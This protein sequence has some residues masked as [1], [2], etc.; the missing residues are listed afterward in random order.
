MGKVYLVRSRSSRL[1]FAVKRAKGLGDSERRNFLAELQTWIGLPDHSNLVPCRFFRTV[2][3]ETLIFA[4]YVDGGSLSQWIESRRLYEGGPKVALERMLDVAIQFAW[5]LHCLHELGLVH[6]DVKP[7]NVLMAGDGKAAV[8]GVKAR[9]TD[10]G[11]ARAKAAGGERVIPEPGRGILVSSG[12][13][14][15]AYCSPEQAARQPLSSKTDMW[16]WGVSVLEMFT[17]EVTWHSGQV[18]AEVL[19]EYLR[20]SENDGLIPAMPAGVVE[21]LKG[22]FRG[23]PAQ[24]WKSLAEVVDRLKAVFRDTAGVQY[25]L[26]LDGIDR[27]T[28][29]QSGIKERRTREGAPWIDPREWLERALRAEGRDPAEA[30]ALVSKHGGSRRGELVGDL[31]IYD[32]SRR[33]YERLL[34]AGRKELESELAELC[35]NKAL[36]HRTTDDIP[37]AL[38]E[39]DRAIEI[40]ERLVHKEK[41]WD[42]ASAL[43]GDY[44]NKAASVSLLGNHREAAALIERAIEVFERLVHQEKRWDLAN[45]LAAAYLN[46]AVAVRALGDHKMAAALGDRGIEIYERL[47]RKAGQQELAKDL[48]MAYMNKAVSVQ[49]EQQQSAVELYHRAIEILERLVHQEGQ[50]ELFHNLATAYMD[51][52][53]VVR[54]LG[55]TRAAMGLYDRAMEIWERLVHKEGRRELAENLANAYINKAVA[56]EN[57]EDNQV[58]LGLYARAIELLERLVRQ[59]GRRELSSILAVAYLNKANVM[60]ASGQRQAAL[61]LYDQGIEIRERLVNREG[62]RELAGDLAYARAARAW[63]MIDLGE[64]ARGAKE[65][66][67]ATDM[68]H[69]EIASS[70]RADL[71]LAMQWIT[72][73]ISSPR[74]P[75]KPLLQTKAQPGPLSKPLNPTPFFMP[76]PS[77]ARRVIP[78]EA[79]AFFKQ[80]EDACGRQRWTEALLAYDKG[81]KLYDRVAE[82]WCQYGLVLNNVRRFAEAETAFR[83]AI[84]LDPKLANAYGNLGVLLVR[85]LKRPD[86][87]EQMFLKA[88][89]IDP[90][91]N[92]RRNLDVL[93]R[94]HRK[95]GSPQVREP[96]Q[97][98]AGS[99]TAPGQLLPP[100]VIAQY[101]KDT[102]HEGNGLPSSEG[103][104]V[105][106]ISHDA[107]PSQAGK[108]AEV[109]VC[110]MCGGN[111][112]TSGQWSMDNRALGGAGCRH[113]GNFY[114]QPCVLRTEQ[115]SSVLT[116]ACGR[117][118]TTPQDLGN[119]E[120]LVVFRK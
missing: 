47:V 115:E 21:V 44:M 43:A 48:A 75:P 13:M 52:A 28:V 66:R 112:F 4:E 103:A 119:F 7:G 70:G 78:P 67:E 83:R 86:E 32:E 61:G 30:E 117:S 34:K 77:T 26:A 9:V 105:V 108:L 71:Q 82:A 50:R 100:D 27:R 73:K 42:L 120:E 62:R 24:R 109:L 64:L 22:C 118:S 97:P 87:A 58:A 63:V 91:H 29:P 12:G 90:N 72:E 81:F 113:C 39:Y 94:Q 2:G 51:K 110:K 6:Q 107:T 89:E 98:R 95:T 17:G 33:I 8:Q 54:F 18:A 49:R 16:S 40:L 79:I 20:E 84:E 41:R 96:S 76:M 38:G 25:D 106:R 114:C 111:F 65:G 93:R 101:V 55:D 14:T 23:E 11:L 69:S 60:A 19:E 92:A 35:F 5:G 116:C 80:A 57:H 85:D 45:G 15:P 36:V 104:R 10:Y 53:I 1:A 102:D 68:L 37:G 31:A 74:E 3:E 99:L 56:V 46:K 88:L 59:E